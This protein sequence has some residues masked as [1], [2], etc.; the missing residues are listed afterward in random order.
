MKWVRRLI[1]AAVALAGLAAFSAYKLSLGENQASATEGQL[2]RVPAF[3]LTDHQG[4]IVTDRDLAGRVWVAS[5]VFTRCATVCPLL[6]AKFKQLQG[7]LSDLGGVQ[8]VSLSVDPEYDTPEVL[9]RYAA[10]HQADPTRWRFLTGSLASIEQTIVEGFKIHVGERKDSPA[11]PTL[12]EIMHGEHFVVV[13]RD[14]RIRGYYQSDAAG[15]SA[16]KRAVRALSR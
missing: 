13:D 8:Y 10:R 6:T 4:R 15:L 1:W 3:E 5:F 16:L 9:A 2:G 11:D 12:V 14:G 7:E